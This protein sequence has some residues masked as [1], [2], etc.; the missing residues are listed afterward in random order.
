MMELSPEEIQETSK[1]GVWRK[2]EA[3]VD[4]GGEQNTLTRSRLRLHL[5]L[6]QPRSSMD[7]Q[8][9]LSQLIQIFLP[10]QGSDPIALDPTR[11]QPRA[12]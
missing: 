6:R 5:P 11:R 7:D 8:P 2:R 3:A 4:M 12:R 1:E 10:K 9:R